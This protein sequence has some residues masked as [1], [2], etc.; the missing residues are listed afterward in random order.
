MSSA[1]RRLVRC[2][3]STVLVAAAVAAPASAAGDAAHLATERYYAS[4]AEVSSSPEL[5][6]ERYYASYG[7]AETSSA[8]RSGGDEPVWT[9]IAIAATGASAVALAMRRAV[10]SRRRRS[11]P[12]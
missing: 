2:A 6:R 12:V 8:A 11:V 3:A 9:F 4:Y 5:A 10:L 7:Q 1:P